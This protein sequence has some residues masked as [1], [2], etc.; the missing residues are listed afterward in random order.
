[1][2]RYSVSA[3]SLDAPRQ[4]T[5]AR[6]VHGEQVSHANTGDKQGREKQRLALAQLRGKQQV[7]PQLME[8]DG[9][10][11]VPASARSTFGNSRAFQAGAPTTVSM[12]LVTGHLIPPGAKAG[13]P[14]WRLQAGE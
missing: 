12:H 7:P 9:A 6:C 11:S 2:M 4:W 14:T 3:P 8:I 1:M 13:L 5:S 10:T